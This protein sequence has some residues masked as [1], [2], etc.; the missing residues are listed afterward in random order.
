MTVPGAV[1]RL[2]AVT[3]VTAAGQTQEQSVSPGVLGFLV[4]LAVVVA[5]VPL[6]RSMTGK[7][8]G[9]QHRDTGRAGPDGAAHTVDDA[10]VAPVT[11]EAGSVP[12]SDDAGPATVTDDAGSRQEL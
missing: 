1:A 9:V 4:T 7:I 3:A 5:C 11:D 6:F 12:A 8:R 2:L 10:G